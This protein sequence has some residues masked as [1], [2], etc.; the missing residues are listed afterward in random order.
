MKGFLYGQT[1]YNLLENANHLDEY[2]ALAKAS[3]FD[4]LTITDCNMYGHFKF[5]N[6]C[7][8]NDIK[9]VIGLEYRF[10]A[11]DFSTMKVLLYAKNN[12]GYKNLL[13]ISSM[14]QIDKIDELKDLL[15]YK[16]GI[17]FIFVFSDYLEKIL[18]SREYNL[19]NDF[20]NEIK[21]FDSYIGIS[22]TNRL[23]KFES[24]KMMEDY[25]NS[26]NI[27]VLPIHNCRYLT[28]K[29][30]IIY[31]ALT[32]IAGDKHSI[33]DFE[34]YSFYSEPEDD[35]RI[36]DFINNINLDLF[37]SKISLP[38][39]PNTKGNSSKL[40]LEA[41]CYK[42]LQ[43]RNKNFKKYYDRLDYELNIINQMGY[44]D[45]FLIVWDFIRYSKKNDILVGPGRGSACG[46]LVAYSLGITEVD[47][48]QYELLFE[49]FLNPERVSMPDIDT[50]F[51][52]VDR[53]KVIEY[54]KNLYGEGHICNI[55]AFDT[56]KINLAVRDLARIKKMETSRVDK[57]LD[58]INDDNL[59]IDKLLESYK[60]TD[61]YEFLYI[62]KGL[63]GFPKHV[64]THAAGIILSNVNL[65]DIIPL[66]K[67]IHDLY[68]SQLEAS[69]LEKI[70]LLKMDFLGIRNLT[71][72][73]SMLKQIPNF[74]IQKFRKIPLDD[75]KVY[76]MLSNADTLGI[77]Q[78][79]SQ[80]ISNVLR[81]LKPTV[82]EDLVAVNALYRPG[83]MDNIDEFIRRKHEGGVTYLHPSLEPIL[84]STYGIIVYQEQ[85]MKIAQVF[86]GYSLGEADMLRRAISKKKADVLKNKEREFISRS[87]SLGNSEE[88]AKKI[89]DLIYK[90]ADYGFNRSHSVAY[91]ILAYQMA[92]LK[93]NY[94]P[95]FMSEILN[96]VAS[97][98]E[99]LSKYLKYAKERGLNTFKP[100][101]NISK[102]IFVSTPLG[103][104]MPF[105]SI[106]SIGSNV[107]AKIVE[108]REKNGLF[109]N[110]NDFK[111]R[112]RFLTSSNIEALVYAGALDI[113][114]QTKKSMIE[115]SSQE[116]ELFFKHMDNV[117]E[118]VKEYSFSYLKDMEGKYLGMN[119]EYSPFKDYDLLLKKYKA[120]ALST[121]KY[122]QVSRCVVY[123]SDVREITTKKNDKM[124][125]GSLED[126]SIV[127]RFVI[128][129][130]IYRTLDMQIE[131]N[132]MYLILG[133]LDKDN[134]ND[135]SISINRIAKIEILD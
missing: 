126:D 130:K 58:M 31:E 21:K 118:N 108:E 86:A 44:N 47:P 133:V 11:I 77:F 30:S 12:E 61:M 91:G 119:I 37:K 71:M 2:V 104:F 5:Y 76:K 111:Q 22:Y 98:K 101:I 16:N 92:Y 114:G 129:P 127:K 83:P 51:P 34:D 99:V 29:D 72:I 75:P 43:K 62:A 106:F 32:E 53:D 78:L 74:D 35:R 69:D 110:Y 46:S 33:S 15:D 52:D 122:K 64:S 7:I 18:C 107:S 112:C 132:N 28:S 41:L 116:D 24:N 60:N 38:K 40:Y 42:G 50:D 135:D 68:Q 9:P 121:L 105:I 117:I 8:E 109:K 54:V 10:K 25:A 57:L 134:R 39:F 88:I 93:A 73:D 66:Q 94:F 90:F 48:L 36:D 56:F 84:K 13:H 96:N 97:N 55:S 85:I 19:V 4:F 100:N 1:E 103:L 20:F 27:R 65:F 3:A 82:F 81:K 128:F 89:Y 59:G 26:H 80:G 102:S 113:F 67:G 63:I 125:I 6:K 124:L 17:S 79:E 123:I 70:G 23:D 115:V 14:V 131:K 87:K 49:R 120:Q 45:Y 95:V